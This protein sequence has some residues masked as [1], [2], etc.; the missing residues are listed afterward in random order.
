MGYTTYDAVIDRDNK[1]ATLI[2]QNTVQDFIDEFSELVDDYLGVI[3]EVPFSPVPAVIKGIVTD[4]V[5]AKIWS[6]IL[7]K[8]DSEESKEGTN[9][10]AAAEKRLECYRVKEIAAD[11]PFRPDLF[12]SSARLRTGVV[13]QEDGSL[14][15]LPTSSR[16]DLMWS[17]TMNKPPV[18]RGL[19]WRSLK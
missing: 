8:T 12:L 19:D 14:L 18:T 6:E 10:L 15:L 3:Y 4:M 7:L 17:N 11:V 2:G 9:L 13:R 1:L 16:G 5:L